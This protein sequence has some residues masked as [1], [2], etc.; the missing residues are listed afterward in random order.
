MTAHADTTTL[1]F[2][3]S[4]PIL[5]PRKPIPWEHVVSH[6]L[7]PYRCHSAQEQVAQASTGLLSFLSRSHHKRKR[8][9]VGRD[10]I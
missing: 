5:K 8:V 2:A 10:W 4:L 3:D 9:S 6:P 1:I 7:D